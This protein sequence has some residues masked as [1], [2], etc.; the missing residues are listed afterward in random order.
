VADGED[1]VVRDPVDAV[2]AGKVL[3]A[4]AG[5]GLVALG[6]A[7][8]ERIGVGGLPVDR[9]TGVL[10]GGVAL[11]VND[12]GVAGVVGSGDARQD[13]QSEHADCCCVEE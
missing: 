4:V 1:V 6:E 10:G 12:Q 3:R 8:L 2:R 7:G 11:P 5:P 13:E 9:R